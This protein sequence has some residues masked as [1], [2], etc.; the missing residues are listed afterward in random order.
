MAFIS[1]WS[2][3]TVFGPFREIQKSKMADQ[4]DRH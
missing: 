1:F 2:I 3:L 4:G